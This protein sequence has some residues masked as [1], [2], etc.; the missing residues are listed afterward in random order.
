[1]AELEREMAALI[2]TASRVVGGSYHGEGHHRA[3]GGAWRRG[4][5]R[6]PPPSQPR[7]DPGLPDTYPASTPPSYYY[8]PGGEG[9]GG[10]A[11]SVEQAGR[12]RV[13]V[14]DGGRDQWMT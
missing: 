13:S 9:G 6:S 4:V 3:A 10:G 8:H 2:A 12:A 14:V 11:A 5:Q 7:F 1:M